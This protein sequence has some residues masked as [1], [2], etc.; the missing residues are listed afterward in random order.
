MRP[1]LPDRLSALDFPSAAREVLRHLRQV[2]GLETCALSRKQDERYVFLY[3]DDDTGVLH[4]GLALSWGDTLC[5]RMV[6]GRAPR[7][8]PD[9]A[10]APG[11]AEAAQALG[12]SLGAVFSI[13]LVDGHGELLGTLCGASPRRHGSDLLAHQPLME[14]LAGLLATLLSYELRL[15]HEAR[16]AELAERAA[17]RDPLT[18]LGNRRLWDRMLEAEQA[19]CTRYG[20][21]AAVVVLDVD[22]LKAVNDRSGH[23]A[24]DS[25]L[26]AVAGAVRDALR[27]YD[28]A[29]RLGGDEFGLLVADC[30]EAHAAAVVARLREVLERATVGVAVG[31]ALSEGDGVVRAW[32]HADRA[33][34]QD[35]G[36]RR[37]IT[38]RPARRAAEVVPAPDSMLQELLDLARRQLRADIAFVGAFTDDTR[39]LRAIAA[40]EP[41]PIG[42]GWA[43]PL[44][45]TLCQR[46]LDG[47]L[48][49]VIPD[50]AREPECAT[51][52]ATRDFGIGSYVGVPVLLADGRLYGTLC[53]LSH[54]PDPRLSDRDADVLA[55]VAAT[56]GRL[57]DAEEH[58]RSVRRAVLDR[59]DDVL[60]AGALD[61]VYQPV[62]HLQQAVVVGVEA[63]ARFRPS[64]QRPPDVWF[65]EAAQVGMHAE[66]EL[67]AARRALAGATELPGFLALNFSAT[68]ICSPAF[69]ALLEEVHL[70]R[71]VVE[72][73]EHEEVEDYAPV[74]AALEPLRRRGLRVAVDDAGAGFASLRHVV[75][76]SPDILKLDLSLVRGIDTDSARQELAAA[77]TAFAGKTGADVVAEGVETQAELEALARVGV[78]LV[79]GWHLCPGLPAAELLARRWG[80]PGPRRAVDAH[81]AVGG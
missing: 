28:V 52:P 57:L 67:L 6:D 5:S 34:Y 8:A 10:A 17:D 35:K 63:L 54:A 50:T 39:V 76:L 46:I 42:P 74:L 2:T 22:G 73:S 43:E 72:V 78:Q 65:A 68:T 41:L 47:R 33:M 58:G 23:A 20:S 25:A 19:R 7:V 4:E 31:L 70:R 77:L 81:V 45:A 60:T 21:R 48:P 79:Q 27:P 55:G 18:G 69:A 15:Q 3:T 40:D 12:L 51:L 59:V 13:P 24:G 1:E 64:P 53:C 14:V 49:R 36:A 16:R 56:L 11:Y 44:E 30:D 9:L 71:V 38:P 80:L 62:V 37:T 75:R 32:Q 66:L 61:I 29:C 26:C